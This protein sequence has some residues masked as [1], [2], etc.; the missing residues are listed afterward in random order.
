M[1]EMI[2]VF[3]RLPSCEF[4][5]CLFYSDKDEFYIGYCIVD[6]NFKY[7]LSEDTGK[8]FLIADD[9]KSESEDEK[10]THWVKLPNMRKS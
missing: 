10:V 4:E 9:T 5:Y 1:I 7:F 3:D 6:N 2:S 8:E